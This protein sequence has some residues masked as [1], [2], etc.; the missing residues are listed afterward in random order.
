MTAD[1]PILIPE[2]A[3]GRPGMGQG[4]YT[5]FQFSRV[6]GQPAALNF[7]APIPLE[8]A[9][10]VEAVDSGW[11]LLD[12]DT[13][14]M[15]A[16]SQAEVLDEFASTE[17]VGVDDARRARLTFWADGLEHDAPLCFSC[18]TH[19][20]SMKV[21]A[22][23]LSDGSGRFAS[24]WTPPDWIAGDTGRVDDA[25][26]WTVLDCSQGFYVSRHPASPRPAV[27]V[28]YAVE[29]LGP[30][31]AG[32]HYTVVASDGRWTGGWD[33]RKKGAGACLFDESGRVLARSDSLWVAT[34]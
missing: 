27:T 33:G 4:G 14:I 9:L 29:V 19:E 25:A 2:W 23:L 21:Q 12:G 11:V 7:R 26:I 6:I 16:V 22:G 28:R 1:D 24:D 13:V 20:G 3:Q 18:G 10:R 8:T 5:A 32:E 15:D 31:Q 30:V 34:G 17:P